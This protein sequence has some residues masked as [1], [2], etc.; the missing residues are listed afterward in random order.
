MASAKVVAVV[1]LALVLSAEAV[2]RHQVQEQFSRASTMSHTIRNLVLRH[3]EESKQGSRVLTKE[4]SIKVHNAVDDAKK[5]CEYEGQ[6]VV[7]GKPCELPKCVYEGQRNC[8]PESKLGEIVGVVVFLLLVAAGGAG[9]GVAAWNARVAFE[10]KNATKFNTTATPL[11]LQSFFFTPAAGCPVGCQFARFFVGMGSGILFGFLDNFGLFYGMD[12]LD[13]LFQKFWF[14]DEPLVLAGYGNTFSDM[15]GAFMGT[16][17]GQMIQDWTG[18]T[19]TPLISQAFGITIGC[20]LGVLIPRLVLKGNADAKMEYEPEEIAALIRIAKGEEL[21]A[22]DIDTLMELFDKLDASVDKHL[23]GEV[24][25][26]TLGK[27]PELAAL[28]PMFEKADQLGFADGSLTREEFRKVIMEAAGLAYEPPPITKKQITKYLEPLFDKVAQLRGDK[29]TAEIDEL[30]LSP[31]FI[32]MEKIFRSK[33]QKNKDKDSL[34]REQ[35]MESLKEAQTKQDELVDAKK[36]RAKEKKS[37]ADL[38]LPTSIHIGNVAALFDKILKDHNEKYDTPDGKEVEVEHLLKVK[39]IRPYV[40]AVRKVTKKMP[41]KLDVDALKAGLRK[42][43]I[44]NKI[45]HYE[46]KIDE[47]VVLKA[48]KDAKT[49][50]SDKDV[51]IKELIAGLKDVL[52]EL[53]QADLKRELHWVDD[54]GTGDGDEYA[55]KK[56]TGDG[57]VNE[58]EVKQ[59][60]NRFNAR[61][62]YEKLKNILEKKEG[63]VKGPKVDKAPKVDKGPKEVLKVKPI[64]SRKI[65]DKQT[66][67]LKTTQCPPDAEKVKTCLE[68]EP[69]CCVLEGDKT[70]VECFGKDPE[71]DKFDCVDLRT[72]SP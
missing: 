11:N 57:S 56:G 15:I 53:Q 31:E 20:I 44:E 1:L 55:K 36:R 58:Q 47:A 19:E 38:D 68:T 35:F 3:L 66:H 72:Y 17:L 39:A 64:E 13:P 48:F 67:K 69:F 5:Y 16:F 7:T 27:Q 24:S 43:I 50:E 45:T 59:A 4:Q 71:K 32:N 26:E 70:Q 6:D 25:L 23:K 30:L 37:D 42:Y 2:S 49:K 65:S 29:N 52:S 54:M 40:E 51:E 46:E 62:G 21:S 60:V 9:L 14:A 18:I 10:Q 41:E 63:K 33:S 61:H 34:T 22:D 12:K 8:K 28:M